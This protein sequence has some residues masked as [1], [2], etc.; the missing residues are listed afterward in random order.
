MEVAAALRERRSVRSFENRDVEEEK[1]RMVL[2]AGRLSPSA[3]NRQE[4]KFIVVRSADKRKKL[5]DAACGQSFVGQAP[6]VLVACATESEAI[7]TCG[8]PA[9]TVDVSIAFAYMLL[10][11]CELGLGTC[12]IGAFKEDEVKE[13]LGIPEHIRVVAMSPLG[14]PTHKSPP[15]PRKDFAEIVCFEEYV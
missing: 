1:L 4:W 11:A 8:Q 15:R 2:E 9:Y 12:W 10:Q 6:V 13:I 5:V 7:M 3:V 14:Y